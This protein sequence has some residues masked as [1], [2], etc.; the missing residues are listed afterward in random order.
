MQ[1]KDLQQVCVGRATLFP[2]AMHLG[3]LE[4]VCL[5]LHILNGRLGESTHALLCD[6]SAVKGIL[7]HFRSPAIILWGL[8]FQSLPELYKEEIAC[9]VGLFFPLYNHE[10]SPQTLLNE[11]DNTFQHDETE[12]FT[13]C[14]CVQLAVTAEFVPRKYQ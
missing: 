12:P 14:S 3:M 2:A 13:S 9:V 6:S 1:Q 11:Q 7:G 8:R 10:C 4:L 5:L